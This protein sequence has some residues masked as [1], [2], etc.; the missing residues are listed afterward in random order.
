MQT[1]IPPFHATKIPGAY[2]NRAT[3]PIKLHK[4]FTKRRRPVV[5][6]ASKDDISHAP[7]VEYDDFVSDDTHVVLDSTQISSVLERLKSSGRDSVLDADWEEDFLSFAETASDEMDNG[8]ENE[9]NAKEAQVVEED[10]V[11]IGQQQ[12]K[13]GAMEYFCQENL[14]YMPSW[15]RQMYLDGAHEELENAA[16][17]FPHQQ[18]LHDIVARKKGTDPSQL[19][20]GDG[21]IDCT[22]GDVAD[23]YFI[24][25]E[26][27]VDIMLSY[28]VP[29]P[30]TAATSVRNNMTT[31]EIERMLKLVTTFDA[32]DLAERYSDKSLNEL[33]DDYDIDVQ[34]IVSVCEKEGLYLCSGEHTR[35]SLVR[36]NRVLD[37][38]FRGAE[39]GQPYPPLLEGLE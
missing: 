6:V 22:A 21:I 13:K 25:I 37:I 38:I 23:D 20:L 9:K 11:P 17:K 5:A 1:F 10:Q 30:V 32:L 19:V 29:T 35:L 31:E 24:P 16:Q 27:V 34:K 28:G 3:N 2:G 39:M 8:N 4:V 12:T 14:P 7:E 33:A 18:R 15:A 36:E 26:L